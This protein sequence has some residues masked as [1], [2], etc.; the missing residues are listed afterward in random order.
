MLSEPLAWVVGSVVLYA[1]ATNLAWAAEVGDGRHSMLR[2]ARMISRDPRAVELLRAA[3]LLGV[4]VLALA[5]RVAHPTSLGL[6]IPASLAASVAAL[7]VVA[8]TVIAI[9]G[10]RSMLARAL[11]WTWRAEAIVPPADQLARL[12]LVALLLESHWAFFRAAGLSVAGANPTLAVYVALGL[13]AVEAWSNPA[14]RVVHDGT[15]GAARQARTGALAVMSGTVF[16]ITGSSISS[17]VGHLLVGVAVM[18]LLPSPAQDA[19]REG[20][21]SDVSSVEPTIV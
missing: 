20:A 8:A 7:A 1:A 12:A 9:I 11:G 21:G 3:Y 6:V 2:R 14:L 13:L 16:L 4:P 15:L 19:D 17:L 18:A 10:S 5:T